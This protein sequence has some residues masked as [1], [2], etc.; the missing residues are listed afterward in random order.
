MYARTSA[1]LTF[2]IREA[3]TGL[4]IAEPGVVY[5]PDWRPTYPGHAPGNSAASE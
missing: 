5:V 2:R 1:P 3:I 4:N